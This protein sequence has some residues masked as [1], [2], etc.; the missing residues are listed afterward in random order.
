MR[1][2]WVDIT[3]WLRESGKDLKSLHHLN[4]DNKVVAV[5]A[6]WKTRGQTAVWI[7]YTPEVT[8][9]WDDLPRVHLGDAKGQRLKAPNAEAAKIRAVNK[10]VLHWQDQALAG[11]RLLNRIEEG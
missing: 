5:L 4:I 7:L 6:L 11:I 9:G 2:K 8:G 3:I 1:A 10:L